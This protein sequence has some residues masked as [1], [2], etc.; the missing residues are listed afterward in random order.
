MLALTLKKIQ[1]LVISK[2][3]LIINISKI[4]IAAGL[5]YYLI[6]YI[7]PARI[8]ETFLNADYG[9][10][11]LAF[12]LTFVNIFLQFLK[13]KEL[14]NSILEVKE[15]KP[16][17]YSLFYGFSAGIITPFNA[18]EYFGRA[19]PLKN[20]SI[21]KVTIATAIDKLFPLLIVTFTGSVASIF[22]LKKFYEIPAFIFWALLLLIIVLYILVFNLMNNRVFWKNLIFKKLKRVR[23]LSKQIEK[24]KVLTLLNSKTTNRLSVI[25][26]LFVLTYTLQF[27]ILI[28]AFS[29]NNNFLFILWASNLVMFAKSMIPPLTFGELGIREGVAL[30]F[31]GAI[32]VADSPIFD[33]SLVLFFINIII[34]SLIGLILLTK[35]S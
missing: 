1:Y 6:S 11:S 27:A 4:L 3:S 5:L 7:E 13:W 2:K 25:S 19:L 24:I 30:F 14:C 21:L 8:T 22:F 31:F 33:A 18:G 28:T 20:I 26:F 12:F 35:K 23:L 16:I 10:I 34:P 17:I 29:E 32:G 15:N 9:Y